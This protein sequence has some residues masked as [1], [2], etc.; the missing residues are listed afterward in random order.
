MGP[1]QCLPL[2]PAFAPSLASDL[3][4]RFLRRHLR[5]RISLPNHS[6][7]EQHR[8]SSDFRT[9]LFLLSISISFTPSLLTSFSSSPHA[10]LAADSSSLALFVS[11]QCTAH[12]TGFHHIAAVGSHA[13]SLL[14]P[15][16]ET[17]DSTLRIHALHLNVARLFSSLRDFPG[18][19]ALLSPR[20]A[21][22]RHSHAASCRPSRGYFRVIA[23]YH[24]RRVL[25]FSHSQQ[26]RGRFRRGQRRIASSSHR[27]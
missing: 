20:R 15:V 5:E 21:A 24:L 11:Q 9:F 13:Q 3:S 14:T 7:R 1:A 18:L 25:A 4:L 6:Y 12:F 26:H 10:L 19:R 2:S 23:G 27:D 8:L 17:V 16:I 22:G